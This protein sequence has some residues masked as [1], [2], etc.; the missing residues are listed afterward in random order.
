MTTEDPLLERA[1]IRAKQ[2]REFYRHLI[3]YVLVCT[4]LVVLDLTDDD[5]SNTERFLG[6]NWAFWPVIGW[7]TAVA[8]HGFKTFVGSASADRWEERKAQQLYEKEKLR[9]R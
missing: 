2:Q 7:G 5:P 9:D 3:I 1:R 4:L 8:I 6:L